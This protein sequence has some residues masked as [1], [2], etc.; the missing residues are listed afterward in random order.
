LNFTDKAN[1]EKQFARL[2]Q[3][4]EQPDPILEAVACPYPGM[5]PFTTK[6]DARFFYGREQEIEKLLLRLGKQ[7][8]FFIIGTSGSGKSSLIFAG[9][10]PE[11]EKKQPGKWL[12]KSLRPGQTASETPMQKLAKELGGENL[13][14]S[15]TVEQYNQ[16][17][18]SLLEQEN[19]EAKIL[20][21]IDQ[22]EELFAPSTTKE[23]A[24]L[25]I[26]TIKSLRQVERISL[27][28]AM[29]ADFYPD[30][31]NSKL[32]SLQE[33]ERV[34]I[35]PLR[36]EKLREAIVTPAA[37]CGVYVETKLVERLL[38]DAADE[39]VVL[40]LLQVTMERLWKRMERRLLTLSAYEKLGEEAS[41]IHPSGLAV[42]IA[43]HAEDTLKKLSEAQ[44]KIA[45]RIF[46]RLV[47]FGEG[48]A[49]TRRQQTKK[50][51]QSVKDNP[52]EFEDTLEH[53]VKDRL[54]FPTYGE[55]NKDEETKIDLAHET[56]IESWPT[57]QQWLKDWRNK[58]KIR[59]KL[60]AKVDDWIESKKK[61]GLLDRVQL[62]EAD[63]W[64][65]SDDAKELG[66]S[67]NLLDLVEASHQ[68][69]REELRKQRN[70]R[71]I[72]TNLAVGVGLAAIVAI[73]Q[74]SQAREQTRLAN[75]RHL[76]SQPLI[77]SEN[78]PDL[79]LLL[80]LEALDRATKL[81]AKAEMLR[82]RS[83]LFKIL[84]VNPNLSAY[85]HGDLHG[86]SQELRSVALSPDGRRLASASGDAILLWDV[87]RR[88]LIAPPTDAQAIG[89][90]DRGIVFNPDGTK[91]AYGRDDGSIIVLDLSQQ[92]KPLNNPSC[93][94]PPYPK[95]PQGHSLSKHGGLKKLISV[96]SLA[97]NPADPKKLVS[98]GYDGKLILWDVAQCKR[99]ATYLEHKPLAVNSVAF[100]RNGKLL[101]S[102]GDYRRMILRDVKENSLQLQG[103]KDKSNDPNN[104]WISSL[105]FNPTNEMSLAVGSSDHQ[106]YLWDL[107]KCKSKI[108][109][110]HDSWVNSVAFNKDG[111]R[112][113]SGGQDGTVIV[114][115]VKTLQPIGEPLI[116]HNGEVQGVAFNPREPD[117]LVSVGYDRDIILWDLKASSRFGK[118][119]DGHEGE[120]SS[121]DISRDNQWLASSSAQ[122]TCNLKI[123]GFCPGKIFL[124]K[125]Q[126]SQGWQFHRDPLD[127]LENQGN[128]ANDGRI[129]SIA[130]NP[131]GTILASGDANNTVILWDVI[132]HKLLRRLNQHLNHVTSVAFS[133]EGK[134]LGSVDG[135]GTLNLWDITNP[136]TRIPL[137]SE[138]RNDSFRSVAF[139]SDNKWL[140]TGSWNP[141]V[142]R[143]WKIVKNEGQQRL[144]EISLPQD[145]NI[146]LVN[147]VAFSPDNKI[148]AAGGFRHFLYLWDIETRELLV[149]QL[150]AHRSQVNSVA[151]SRDPNSEILLASGS[152]DGNIILWVW[153]SA[154]RRLEQ[155][156]KWRGHDDAVTSMVFSW[157]N[158]TLVSGGKDGKVKI[159][160]VS[161]DKWQE[162]SC[163]I[164][165]RNLTS[166]EWKELIS[167]YTKQPRQSI[168]PNLH[169]P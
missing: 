128:Q 30:L 158:K 31:M 58:E 145:S 78:Q 157:D 133:L 123:H 97:F 72:M 140:A 142:V 56:I 107:K 89:L 47:Q 147:S 117:K 153:D 99:I 102:G 1:Y 6:D 11:L 27:I 63:D 130:F 76:T 2:H 93:T 32:W 104:I 77:A 49:D 101:A 60:R 90:M 125:W 114:W 160:D 21:I 67:Q 87:I 82:A 91:L 4:L 169:L 44:K 75:L 139:S 48:R 52:R 132:N 86:H 111:T 143:L 70:R 122:Q 40:P 150:I 10:V 80:S 151:F 110:R 51:L 137:L 71:I 167:P 146:E 38:I 81:D 131:D 156:A 55:E 73:I 109:G 22:F 46:I 23:Q 161:L 152:N 113:V 62:K 28:L 79:A 96:R 95:D 148:L 65:N 8:Y 68:A 57:F 154:N 100:S 85:L 127:P 12:I 45:R 33:F 15:Q 41:I 141:G 119:L 121:V 134:K 120:V 144:E 25:F 88:E 14:D 16:L 136:K 3:L 50:E 43:L 129:S 138:G 112:L 115:D 37:N 69:I 36:G 61:A 74:F 17:I 9:L 165:N 5:K 59:R 53:L 20:L 124:W 35:A 168:C 155:L 116:G 149:R 13:N 92:E 126:D 7:N 64:L 24:K 162:I 135:S 105:A 98:A 18:N 39:P 166:G 103:C 54:L 84:Q 19:P 108:L 118:I 42:A 26:T 29:R 83:N 163:R 94:L 66:F 159:W 164:A 106:I 34:E